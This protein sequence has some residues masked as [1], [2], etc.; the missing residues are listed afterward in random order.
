[1]I[2]DFP[3]SWKVPVRNGTE[4][5]S[6]QNEFKNK[7]TYV[8]RTFLDGIKKIIQKTGTKNWSPNPLSKFLFF[9]TPRPWL[10]PRACS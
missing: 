10:Q 6:I 4:L 7:I 2:S 3:L 8:S 9:A 5:D 1:V